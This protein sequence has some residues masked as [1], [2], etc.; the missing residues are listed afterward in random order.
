[1]P[2]LERCNTSAGPRLYLD[3]EPISIG[4]EIQ[5]RESDQWDM[6]GGMSEQIRCDQCEKLIP[7]G[8]LRCRLCGQVID[9]GQMRSAFPNR[10]DFEWMMISLL[11]LGATCAAVGSIGVF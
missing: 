4:H 2:H 9:P 7:A 8:D 3:G 6:I 10:G 11:I 5:I 1:M